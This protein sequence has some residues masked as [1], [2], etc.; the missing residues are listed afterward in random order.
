MIIIFSKEYPLLKTITPILQLW[1]DSGFGKFDRFFIFLNM[2]WKK[3]ILFRNAHMISRKLLS[4]FLRQKSHVS[5]MLIWTRLNNRKI[6][7]RTI[8]T[9]QTLSKTRSL[10]INPVL[11]KCYFVYKHP[12]KNYLNPIHL[13][14]P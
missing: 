1:L 13:G 3:L 14:P 6:N 2:A 5:L 7:H 12:G 9:F 10:A 11:G 4:V 8:K